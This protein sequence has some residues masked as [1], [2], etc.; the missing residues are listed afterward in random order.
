MCKAYYTKPWLCNAITCVLD[1]LT[2][3]KITLK[4]SKHGN[5][6]PRL[7][8]VEEVLQTLVSCMHL[9]IKY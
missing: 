6:T 4:M 7:A 9:K 1:L 5:S 8:S 2:V 3:Q